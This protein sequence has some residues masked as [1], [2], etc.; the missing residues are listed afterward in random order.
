MAVVAPSRRQDALPAGVG[1]GELQGKVDRLAAAN[2]KDG[3]GQVA[4]S[5]LGQ[6]AGQRGAVLREQVVIA[7]VE[8][9]Q[10][11]LQGFD[12]HRVAVPEVENAAVAVAVDEA[13][14]AA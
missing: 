14:L 8:L 1:P 10:G 9:V 13:L 12:G 5:Q 2:G 11:A 4:G 6:A 7:N 3:V